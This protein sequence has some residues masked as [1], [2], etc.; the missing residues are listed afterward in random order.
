MHRAHAEI[1]NSGCDTDLATCLFRSDFARHQHRA[2]ACAS[3]TC[4][5]FRTHAFQTWSERRGNPSQRWPSLTRDAC[6]WNGIGHS[7]ERR[8][9]AC[10]NVRSVVAT[11]NTLHTSLCVALGPGNLSKSGLL[12]ILRSFASLRQCL[13]WACNAFDGIFA[14]VLLRPLLHF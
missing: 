4:F 7:N 14:C 5:N 13:F 3:R 2:R 1:C 8:D 6:W 11:M 9:I 12:T 10:D